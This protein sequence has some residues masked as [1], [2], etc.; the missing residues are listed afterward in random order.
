VLFGLDWLTNL[1][2]GCFLFGLI[3]TALS[4][5]L[6]VGHLGGAH[7]PSSGAGHWLHMLGGAVDGPAHHIA[8][9]HAPAAHASGPAAQAH[10]AHAAHAPGP[11]APHADGLDSLSPLNLPTL[12]AFLT[13]FGGAGYIFRSTLGL[14]G[15]ISALLALV[16]GVAGSAILFVILSR[17]LWAGQTPPMSRADYYLPGTRARVVSRIA[18]G[19][20]GEIVFYKGG[21]RR[22]EGARGEGAVDLPRGVEVVITRY[23][24]G[25]AYVAA[26]ADAMDIPPP[27][28]ARLGAAG[29]APTQSL[30]GSGP[31]VTRNLRQ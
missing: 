19:G 23:E 22:V 20:T 13:W 14:D 25:L 18:A 30:A 21:S 26:V 7:A 10:G 16:S 17:V 5:F 11:H 1:Y 6:S 27:E 9:G 4:L 8:G 28:V 31:A 2:L 15:P 24:K 29:D 3:F 12:L